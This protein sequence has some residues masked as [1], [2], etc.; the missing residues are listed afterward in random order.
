MQLSRFMRAIAV[1]AVMGSVTLA[2]ASPVNST[3]ALPQTVAA[4]TAPVGTLAELP[5]GAFARLP[6][7]LAEGQAP[8]IIVLLHGAGQTPAEIIT[9]FS[10]FAGCESTV[11][12]A[13]KSAG[14]TWDIIARL[15][16]ASS[17]D[18]SRLGS[19]PAFTSSRDADRVMKAIAD[20]ETSLHH[21]A[22]RLTLVGF[23]DGAT[24]ALALGTDRRNSFTNVVAIS[25][26][27]AVVA[28]RPARR[29]PVLI[30]HGRRDR[31]LPFE[32]TRSTIVP[33]VK[34]SGALVHFE[35]FEGGHEIPDQRRL[36]GQG[37]EES[38]G[39]QCFPP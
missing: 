33:A 26:G 35:P 12:L 11:L 30:M 5:D 39:S 27:M 6:S 22:A 10:T 36:R 15:K 7:S 14:A 32:F 8:I 37:S 2:L 38:G 17:V 18:P 29:R 34:Q 3:A 9:R 13:P 28:A 23:S 19:T 24:F 20:L 4:S 31:S 21:R 25:P 16:L 1:R